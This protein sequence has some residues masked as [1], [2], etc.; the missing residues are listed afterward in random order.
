[1]VWDNFQRGQEPR[2]QRG[3]RS[4]KF[5][6]GTIEAAHCMVLFLQFQCDN[7]KIMM[8]YNQHQRRP[9]PLGM[10]ACET[11][12]PFS[13]MF[14]TDVFMNH[15]NL[16]IPD[17]PCFTGDCV[18]CYVYIMSLQKY[19]CNMSRAFSRQF[20]SIGAGI[21]VDNINKFK[22]YCLS[23]ESKEFFSSVYKF[24]KKAVLDWNRSADCVT[25]CLNMRFVGIREDSAA[26]ARSVV[27]D[28]LLKFGVLK[29]IA[30][31]MWQL[32]DNAKTRR[33]Y[34]YGDRKSNENCTTFFITL[35]HRPITFKESSLHAKI[36]WRHLIS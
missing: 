20:E 8:T 34:S 9:L 15:A 7:C 13:T 11:C 22:D 12:D 36:F 26:G 17:S 33:L 25:L 27:L 1:M 4:N 18:H 14:G 29:Y 3:G 28:M 19:S 31:K 24:K 10:W 5:L 35:N 6:V 30:G 16:H 23:E 32:E 21:N 2:D